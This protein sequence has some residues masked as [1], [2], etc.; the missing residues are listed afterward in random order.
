MTL[1]ELITD[2]GMRPVDV[3]SKARLS[4]RTVKRACAGESIQPMSVYMISVALECDE[5]DIRAAIR[6]SK[7]GAA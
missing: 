2:K 4:E 6:A 7:D 5:S 3:A 1:L